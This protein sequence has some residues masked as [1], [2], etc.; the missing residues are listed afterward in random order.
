[1][2]KVLQGI[3]PSPHAAQVLLSCRR[4]AAVEVGLAV[5]RK[6][7]VDAVLPQVQRHLDADQSQ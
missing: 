4:R 6:R 3:G 7:A 2:E 1:M 5:D